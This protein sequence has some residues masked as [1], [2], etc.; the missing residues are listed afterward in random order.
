MPVSFQKSV[1][2]PQTSGANFQA[3]QPNAPTAPQAPKWNAYK[4]AVRAGDFTAAREHIHTL[5]ALL[6]P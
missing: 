1:G 3:P 2:Y 6:R 5:E 4:A